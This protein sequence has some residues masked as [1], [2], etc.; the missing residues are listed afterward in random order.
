MWELNLSAVSTGDKVQGYFD[1][2]RFKRT[3]SGQSQF[4]EQAAMQAALASKYPGV[5]QQQGLEVSLLLPHVSWFG[6]TVAVPGYSGINYTNYAAFF[7]NTVIP[8]IHAS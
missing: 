2:L 7:Q 8:E 3:I 6:P 1:Y 5:R 4:S